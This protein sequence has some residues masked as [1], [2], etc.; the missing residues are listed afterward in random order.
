M[1]ACGQ[2]AGQMPG[3]TDHSVPLNTREQGSGPGRIGL[4]HITGEAVAAQGEDRLVTIVGTLADLTPGEAIV[5]RSSFRST[6][7]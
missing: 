2:R 3:R 6:T 5:A 7:A 4:P 1:P